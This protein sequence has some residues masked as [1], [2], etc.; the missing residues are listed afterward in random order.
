M[1]KTL[2]TY[3][4]AAPWTVLPVSFVLRTPCFAT[5]RPVSML[6]V[7]GRLCPALDG[8]AGVEGGRAVVAQPGQRG[9]VPRADDP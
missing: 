7:F 1:S 4:R 8:P 9:R 6:T 2:E 3:W 5:D